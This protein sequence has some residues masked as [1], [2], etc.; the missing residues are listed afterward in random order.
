MRR[1]FLLCI[2]LFFLLALTGCTGDPWEDLHVVVIGV[3][4]MSP[5]GIRNASTPVMDSLIAVGAATM[6]ARAVL[7]TSSSPNWASIINGAGPEQHGIT[8]NI[9]QVD[10]HELEPVATGVGPIFPSIFDILAQQRPG[11]LSAS[12]YDWGGFGALYNR[13]AVDIDIDGD[14]PEGTVEEAVRVLI[15]RKPT[16][17]FV[18][19]DHVDHVGH[20]SG[21]G[22][23]AYYESVA[24]ADR[25]IGEVING[26][27]R[28]GIR[29]RT[30]VLV[31]ADHGGIGTGHG[32]E[33]MEEVEVPWIIAGPRIR[34]GIAI[35]E[36]VDTYDTAATVAHLLGLEPP[37]AWVA[38]PVRQALDRPEMPDPPTPG[39]AGVEHVVVIGVDGMS[40]DGVQKARTPHLNRLIGEGA[41]SFTARAVLTTSSSQN[42]ASMIMGA[43]PEQH[44]ITSNDWERDRFTIPPTVEGPEGIFP[45]MFSEVRAARPDARI[46]VSYDW[47]GFGRLFQKSV[48]D[49]EYDAE[50]PQAAVDS[51][52]VAFGRLKPDL[53]FIHLDHVDGAGHG[54]GHG[55]DEYY[56]SVEDADRLIGEVMAGLEAAGMAERTLVIVTSDHG[57]R[58]TG[59]GGESMGE[60]EIPWIVHGPGVAEGT[61]IA[62]PIN[63]Y[64]TASSVLYALGVAQPYAWVGRP[65]LS[66]FGQTAQQSIYIPAARVSPRAGAHVA[67]RLEA[68][69]SVDLPKAVLRYT[70]DGSEPSEAS[71]QVTGP[72]PISVSGELKVRPFVAGLAG[73]VTTERYTLLEP[74]VAYG[75]TYQIY[76]G[77]WEQLPDF[78]GLKA[79]SKGVTP[80]VSLHGLKGRPDDWFAVRFS[81]SLLIRAAGAYTFHLTSDDGSRLRIDGTTVVDKDSRGGGSVSGTI[82]LEQGRHPIE[83]TYFETYGENV[84]ALRYEGPGVPVQ[85]VPVDVLFPELP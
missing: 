46:V 20:D 81:G 61:R 78:D 85:P 39:V 30:V 68:V 19:L 43:G 15:D 12:V 47:G 73:P 23:P 35:E 7:P 9:W 67:D 36:P 80:E 5:D 3:D 74:G 48:V 18:H 33:T 38:R 79:E 64:D 10:N 29:E 40:P 51:A 1:T 71:P 13:E 24:E 58:G 21:H 60:M 83:V 42:W 69:V 41:Y 14:G 65:V 37:A 56:A 57:G 72:I 63:T 75:L 16:L 34:K 76:V 4:A 62:D 31:T 8:S 26:L 28:A 32:G 70:L 55:S 11:A 22:S 45:T 2:P 27:Q 52:V 6:R 54:Y 53:T 66:A 82:V 59:H 17:L 84:L 44:G 50:G 77:E 49:L 25:L